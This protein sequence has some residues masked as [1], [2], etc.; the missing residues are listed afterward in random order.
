VL[1]FLYALFYIILGHAYM[2]V[3]QAR[4]ARCG[5]SARACGADS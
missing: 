5:A 2:A 3:E 4:R 1:S